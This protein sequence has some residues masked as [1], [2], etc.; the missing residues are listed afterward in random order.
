MV[1]QHNMQAMNAN[2]MLG[3]T[4]G[5]QSKSTEKLSSGYRINR[6]A[7][8]AAGLSISEKMRFQI[9][10]LT[11]GVKNM[12]EGVNY[13][14][15]AD[16]ALHEVHGMLQRINELSIQSANGTNSDTERM[17]L[18]QE[19]QHLKE[20][21][22]RI[23][24]TTKYNEEFIFKCED[25]ELEA[26]LEPYKLGLSGY[27]DDLYIYNETYD[28]TT[29]TATFGGIAYRGKRYEWSS[30]DPA[31]YDSTTGT[32]HAGTYSL[33]AEDGS[34][35]SLVCEEGSKPPEVSREFQVSANGSGII[36]NNECI[37]WSQVK[38]ADGHK[39]NEGGIENKPYSF[40][41]HGVTATFT[42]D[43]AD[44][45]LDVMN[46]L[47]DIKWQSTY[48]LPTEK[49]A[50][51]TDFSKTYTTFKNNDEVKRYLDGDPN[52]ADHMYTLR[53]DD[54]GLWLEQNGTAVANS[55]KT[56]ADLGI[57]N[58]GDQSKDIWSDKTYKYTYDPAPA[59]SDTISFTFQVV[60]EISKDSAINALDG[61]T[62][63]GIQSSVDLDNH[64][65]LTMD[66]NYS[67]V[68]SGKIN[69]DT[70]NLTLGEEY[71]LGRDYTTTSDT[72]GSTNLVYDKNTNSFSAVYTNTLDGTTTTKTYN[73]TNVETSNIISTI[74]N[75]IKADMHDYLEVIKA[76]Y[77]A[78]ATS[79]TET[80]L[81]TLLSPNNIT[82][83]GGTTYLED[84]VKL[85]PA[86]ITAGKLNSTLNVYAPT[87]YAGASIDFSG[88]GTSFEL[89]DLIGMGF[90]STCQTCSNHYS[91]QFT[92]PDITQANWS[93]TTPNPNNPDQNS[94]QYSSKRDGANYTLYIDVSSMDGKIND[95]VA[96]TN[97]L[98]DI[99]D[100]S[101]Y[102]FHFTQYASY[103]DDAKLYI[104]DN[105]PQYVSNGVS[106]A[107]DATFS[108][109]AY[110]FNSVAEYNINLY[111]TDNSA[112]YVS[113]QYEYDYK[114]IFAPSN[115]VFEYEENAAGKYVQLTDGTYVVYDAN[116]PDHQTLKRYNIKKV[117][118][119]TSTGSG[120]LDDYLDEYI[121]DHIL[122][123]TANASQMDL[124]SDYAKYNIGNSVN[125]NKAL[126]TEY[127]TPVQIYKEKESGVAPDK[128]GFKIQCSSNT[129]DSIYIER[130]NLSLY[131]IGLKKLSVKTEKLATRAIDMLTAAFVK[132]NT[133][134]SKFGTYQNRLEH[135]IAN[136]NNVAENTTAAESR[137][138]DTDM[139]EELQNLSTDNILVQ[140][141]EAILAQ[142]NSNA[143]N[144]IS[145]LQV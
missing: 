145:L 49:Q 136:A 144:V 99:I 37:P 51:F 114:D 5:Q 109:Y 21:M 84:T 41:Y 13:C 35:L 80:N 45:L 6:A 58:W 32:F 104:F 71:G 42:P 66:G 106:T 8:D 14:K 31:M 34:I 123:E 52:F 139:A 128:F 88:L 62:L 38:T 85:D 67:N 86:D 53:A 92:T 40:H 63:P 36:I 1:I 107:T 126:I 112:E 44:D 25:Q 15:V 77:I 20:E 118:L 16:G 46:K 33:K 102:D 129:K 93:S 120:T 121:R 134:R 39:I 89:V 140:A 29:K 12:Q 100:A 61:I 78:G 22:E 73:N 56:W 119:D 65:D 10:G 11:Q 124:V 143:Q 43:A 91:I 137:I 94:Y 24:E 64:A 50:L 47:S 48:K 142:A 59:G 17:Y 130:Q 115:L 72:F 7:D 111:D 90:N 125:E 87:T 57:T 2:R 18:D 117:D 28:D 23:F 82:G 30:I 60:N 122:Q 4:T 108:P 138:R 19:V 3:I 26:P 113:L 133:V 76:R 27:P 69:R 97:A 79:P 135:S 70:L 55:N 74:K 54:T 68:M 127:N 110:G 9:R 95:G 116:N 101:G 75:Q 105:R 141:G 132:V 98:L 96:F 81:A 103:T 83:K 131:R